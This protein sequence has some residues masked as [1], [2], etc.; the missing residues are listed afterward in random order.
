MNKKNLVIAVVCLIVV[1]GILG[2][3]IFNNFGITGNVVDSNIYDSSLYHDADSNNDLKIELSEVLRINQFFN[4]GIY[5]CQDGT[6]DGYA[7]GE[8]DK[9]CDYHDADYNPGDWNIDLSEFLRVLQFFNVGGYH[10]CPEWD[11]NEEGGFCTTR[12]TCVDFDGTKVIDGKI[13]ENDRSIFKKEILFIHNNWWKVRNRNKF[14]DYCKNGKLIEN[15]CNENGKARAI[16]ID[17]ECVGG[18]CVDNNDCETDGDLIE[19]P[20]DYEDYN[21]NPIYLFFNFEINGNEVI[22]NGGTSSSEGD[23]VKIIFNWGDGT[24]NEQWLPASH[25]YSQSQSYHIEISVFDSNGN[26]N[27]ITKN[28][29]LLSEEPEIIYLEGERVVLQNFDDEYFYLGG[30]SPERT[31]EILDIF[32]DILEE[33][34]HYYNI[35]DKITFIYKSEEECS[36]Y[37]DAFLRSLCAA[38]SSASREREI[39]IGYGFRPTERHPWGVYAHEMS[40][41][42]A[43]QSL[44]FL[45]LA[46]KGYSAFLDEHQAE[47]IPEYIYRTIEKDSDYYEISEEELLDMRLEME[48]NRMIQK[49]A[50]NKYVLDG[51]LFFILVP[52]N[53]K[54][55]DM[56]NVEEYVLGKKQYSKSLSNPT[57]MATITGQALSH[58]IFGLCDKYDDYE[59]IARFNKYLKDDYLISVGFSEYNIPNEEEMANYI[60]AA[61]SLAFGVDL[62]NEFIEYLNFPVDDNFYCEYY[63]EL[64]SFEPVYLDLEPG[65][66]THPGYFINANLNNINLEDLSNEESLREISDWIQRNIV[67]ASDY[68][69]NDFEKG[70][71]TAESMVER[72][73]A[74]GC[75]DFAVIFAAMARG[76]GYPVKVVETY[77]EIPVDDEGI[78]GHFFVE[79]YFDGYWHYYNPTHKS[80]LSMI[81]NEDVC[82]NGCLYLPYDELKYIIYHKGRDF[83][84]MGHRNIN[85]ANQEHLFSEHNMAKNQFESL[86]YFEA[87]N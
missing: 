79:V 12:E 45:Y 39:N 74:D 78:H 65:E 37:S 71:Y 54:K 58:F 16:E 75:T 21:P 34:H 72:R 69:A 33:S 23:V 11:E 42:I 68:V 18:A 17:C 81:N 66:Q 44:F 83:W 73:E 62:R 46:E 30:V 32:F 3:L 55:N 77:R 8:G 6:E 50:Y 47:I 29:D 7:P 64:N 4:V 5:H 35:Q 67:D 63:N 56:N 36:T 43:D 14:N 70:A 2:V 25:V 24:I 87:I 19:I 15:Y 20:F 38:A 76:K 57:E 22:I 84:D 85:E 59:A 51:K 52:P 80:F 48:I 10:P 28:I 27:S 53:S 31:V 41:N 1:I 40:H 13:V 26:S 9:S 82:K 61:Y 60:V 86:V 49:N